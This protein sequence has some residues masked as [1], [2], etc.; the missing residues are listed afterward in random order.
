MRS[1]FKGDA[2]N[3]RMEDINKGWEQWFL[4]ESDEHYDSKKCDR[5][6]LKKLHDQALER[7]AGILNFGDFLDLMGGKY[8]KRS[9]KADI[10][11]EY[12]TSSYFDAVV[13]D[14]AKYLE[15]YKNNILLIADG[16]HEISI[17]DRHEI[18]VLDRLS[19]KLGGVNRGKYT[20]WV[21]FQ[22]ILRKTVKSSINLYYT[23]GSG[24]NAPVTRGTIQSARRQD[25]IDADILVSGH[26]HTD[27]ILAR[28]KVRLNDFGNEVMYEQ[29]HVQLGCFKQSFGG[30]WESQKGFGPASMGGY[31]LHF[32]YEDYEIKYELIRAK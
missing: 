6:L 9:S 7:N 24:G 23:H 32:Y 28:P 14:A 12:Q 29:T 5:V 16:N 21:K 27:Y 18:N 11:P 19:E 3:I 26:I 4:L 30:S 2:L 15:P 25:Y 22:F 8:D 20:G 1:E 31:W 13:D 10:R 17:R